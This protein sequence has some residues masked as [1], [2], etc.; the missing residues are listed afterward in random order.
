M[1][2]ATTEAAGRD[3]RRTTGAAAGCPGSAGPALQ[4]AAA[5]GLLLVAKGLAHWVD[6]AHRQFAAGRLSEAARFAAAAAGA[7]AAAGAVRAGAA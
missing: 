6:E 3:R 4:T 2:A 1:S 5:S 7:L